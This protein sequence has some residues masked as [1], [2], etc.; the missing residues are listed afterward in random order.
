LEIY[1]LRHAPA[2]K[3]GTDGYPNDDRPLTKQ[4]F[5]KMKL[6]AAGIGAAVRGVDVVLTSPLIRA[7]D[8]AG[9][10]AKA[11]GYKRKIVVCNE[12]LPEASPAELLQF[13]TKFKQGAKVLLVGHQPGL[14]LIA[15]ALVGSSTPVIDFKKG[16]LCRIDVAGLPLKEPGKLIWLLAPRQLRTLTKNLK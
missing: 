7:A 11:L 10:A 12:L 5:R 6:A 15:S 3:R 9:I 2:V 13:L 1:I 16:S 8:T 4:G 14:G